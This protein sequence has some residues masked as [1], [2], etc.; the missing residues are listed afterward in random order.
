MCPIYVDPYL[1]PSMNTAPVLRVRG[2]VCRCLA[3][4]CQRA[5]VRGADGTALPFVNA[6]ARARVCAWA[7][8]HLRSMRAST[9]RRRRASRS[10]RAGVLLGVG[11]QREHR[12][13]EHRTSH[14][15]VLGMR[16][17]RP[18]A[19]RGGLRSVGRR[20]M[21]GLLRGGAADVCARA[22]A[23]ACSYVYKGCMWMDR[24]WIHSC[25]R[26]PSSALYM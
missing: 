26:E 15:V 11:L 7:R 24:R 21:C 13:V 14:D 23:C 2:G 16:R 19:H 25:S 20:R 10:R 5:R 6:H 18:G 12:R 8:P 17:F 1:V 9:S 4:A 3:H 22:C